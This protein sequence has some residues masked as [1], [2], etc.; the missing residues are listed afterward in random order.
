MKSS[1]LLIGIKTKKLFKLLSEN[2]ISFRPKYFVRLL[3][4][5]QNAF[6]SSLFSKRENGIVNNKLKTVQLPDNPVFIVGHW[7][8]GTTYLQKLMSFDE[9]FVTPTL[10]Q[11]FIP[12]GF[13]N[14]YKFY[15]PIMK[16]MLGENRPFDN[17]KAGMDEPQEDEFALFR[18]SGYSPLLELIFPKNNKYFL[19]EMVDF[20]PEKESLKNWENSIEFFYKKLSFV[21]K[22]RLLIKNPF[23]SLRIDFL[24]NK[25]PNAKFIHIYRNPIDVVAS[26]V[27]MWSIV[28][29]NNEMNG[30]WEIPSCAEVSGFYD[31]MLTKVNKDLSGMAE[32]SYCEIAFEE[33]EANPVLAI[34]K[35]YSELGLNCSE[36]LMHKING[37]VEN[38]RDYQK[39]IYSI[40]KEEVEIVNSKMEQHK[41]RYGYL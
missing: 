2:K 29:S 19:S 30:K 1:Y 13:V 31:F 18:L 4:I 36:E 24:K 32:G 5:I 22:K 38:N 37:F 17:M 28:G 3:F 14:S 26:T 9:N 33:I 34:K 6:W 21:Y 25:F 27:K 16:R 12:E 39:N 23:H 10:F 41:I 15:R 35:I 8:T 7:R 20:I 11:T 40:S